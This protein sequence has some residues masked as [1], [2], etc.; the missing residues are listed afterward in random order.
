MTSGRHT[1]SEVPRD[2]VSLQSKLDSA[3]DRLSQAR[4]NLQRCSSNYELHESRRILG[5]LLSAFQSSTKDF[6]SSL[7]EILLSASTVVKKLD[8]KVEALEEAVDRLESTAKAS[9][10]E[11]AGAQSFNQELQARHSR[12]TSATTPREESFK[13]REQERHPRLSS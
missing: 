9:K 5:L 10:Q 1:V 12:Q 2:L 6:H 13:E 3:E 7:P 11:L 8:T 4:R